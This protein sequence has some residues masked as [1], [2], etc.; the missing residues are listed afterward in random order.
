MKR[1]HAEAHSPLDPLEFDIIDV[2]E[3]N[4]WLSAINTVVIHQPGSYYVHVDV[5]TCYYGFMKVN[6]KVNG[7]VMFWIQ[8]LTETK[9]GGQSRGQSAILNLSKRD[10]ITIALVDSIKDFTVSC[11]YSGYKDFCTAFFGFLLAP[12]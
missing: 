9:Y 4:A 1:S 2:N 5:A 3:G 12:N 10:V 6:V 8:F 11:I 7:E